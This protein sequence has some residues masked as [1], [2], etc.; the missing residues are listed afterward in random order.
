MIIL[1]N[2]ERA[3]LFIQEMSSPWRH[4]PTHQQLSNKEIVCL[5]AGAPPWRAFLW[6]AENSKAHR[7]ENLP[8]LGGEAELGQSRA[9]LKPI[10]CI[11]VV[12]PAPLLTVSPPKG[13]VLEST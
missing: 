7:L 3:Q 4:P 12:I 5:K 1:D 13:S 6:K 8:C 11:Y 9:V 2:G 10:E